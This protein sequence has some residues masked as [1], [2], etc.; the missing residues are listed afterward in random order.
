M[1]NYLE[2]FD[3]KYLKVSAYALGTFFAAVIIMFLCY[4]SKGVWIRVG[5]IVG[6]VA[7]PLITGIIITYL[8]MPLTNFFDKKLS[9][10]SSTGAVAT[11][12]RAGAVAL[13]YLIVLGI[14]GIALIALF[15]TVYKQVGSL[16]IDSIKSLTTKVESEY[17][18]FTDQVVS[19]LKSQG[20]SSASVGKFMK[21][22]IQSGGSI[23]KNIFFGIIF[24]I[25]FLYDGQRIGKYWKRVVRK[26]LSD[27]V[28]DKCKVFMADADE[29]FSGYIRGQMI[30]AFMVGVLTSVVMVAFGI[31]YGIL[32]GLV[33][34]FGNLIPYLG[35]I[36]GY[37][38]IILS[39]LM[40]GD[41]KSM[42]IGLLLLGVIQVVDGNVI[43]PKLLS[44]SI[45]IHPLYVIVCVIGGGTV[46][47]VL[48]M[49][50]AVPTGALIKKE[51]ERF[52]DYRDKRKAEKSA[53]IKAEGATEE[54]GAPSASEDKAR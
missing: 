26:I 24:S 18:N 52:L 6:A 48:G 21:S 22:L 7:E 30:D 5:K 53:F 29:A 40:R 25:Y 23:L 45:H 43:N 32:I 54:A 17:S 20:Y 2:K 14:L 38:T 1:K 49:L 4:E 19:F 35:P 13:T 42:I 47:G 36:L 8:L 12:S 27:K 10:E 44:N 37:G 41:I 3:K 16:D 39:S 9:K 50:I 15:V 51:F 31:P 33:T 46:G 34:G 28:I 11:A